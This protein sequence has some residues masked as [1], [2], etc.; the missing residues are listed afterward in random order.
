[1]ESDGTLA[2]KFVAPSSDG[3]QR[4]ISMFTPDL[5]CVDFREC[6]DLPANTLV[7]PLPVIRE[8]R[9]LL[10]NIGIDLLVGSDDAVLVS[11]DV[12]A[13]FAA[14]DAENNDDDDDSLADDSAWL[15]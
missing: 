4:E 9:C 7:A 3:H 15:N 5:A 11:P 8:I 10:G 14:W 6:G 12:F 2:V 13:A 1:M